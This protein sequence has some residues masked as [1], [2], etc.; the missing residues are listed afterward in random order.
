[1]KRCGPLFLPTFWDSHTKLKSPHNH[2]HSAL[3]LSLTVSFFSQGVGIFTWLI[4]VTHI[5][6]STTIFYFLRNPPRL[7]SVLPLASF[8]PF[9]LRH[10]P[11]SGFTPISRNQTRR[12]TLLEILVRFAPNF[13]WRFPINHSG[14]FNRFATHTTLER[15]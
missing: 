12:P 5:P 13:F 9:V 10:I 3:R 6:Y 4:H 7:F 8:L 2:T 14:Q 1:M 15:R 11:A